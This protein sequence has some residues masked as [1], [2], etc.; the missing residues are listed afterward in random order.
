MVHDRLCRSAHHIAADLRC[1]VG[2]VYAAAALAL[3]DIVAEDWSPRWGRIYYRAVRAFG[4]AYRSA[5][6]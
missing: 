5:S 1:D 2:R 6:R 4:D 3:R